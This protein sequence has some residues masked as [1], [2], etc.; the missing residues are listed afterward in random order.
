MRLAKARHEQE[1]NAK[2]VRWRGDPDSLRQYSQFR[3]CST[4]PVR[5]SN[6]S[7]ESFQWHRR[8]FSGAQPAALAVVVIDLET[9][10]QPIA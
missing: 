8:A 6:R 5:P 9:L 1:C 10:S 2:W 4:Q 7:R 3:L